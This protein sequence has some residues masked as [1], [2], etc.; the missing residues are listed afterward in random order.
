EVRR[1]QLFGG[2]AENALQRA[3][4][5]FLQRA[6]D[7]GDGDGL[8]GDN[9]E[10]DD[11]DVRGR[12]ADGE[13]VQLAVHRRDD[14]LQGLGGAGG[15]GDHRESS[16]A[17]AAEV[18]VRCVEDDLIVGVAVDRGHDARLD[19][20]RVVDDLDDGREAVRGAGGVRDDV[21]LRCVV[22][23]FVDAQNDGEVFVRGGSGDD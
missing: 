4:R 1:H 16:G 11:R 6:V 22:L 13:A 21:V 7:A 14:E 9:G 3:F 8:L 2:K 19:G 23:V 18:L 5:G 10:V 15:A 17:G 20:E 12:D